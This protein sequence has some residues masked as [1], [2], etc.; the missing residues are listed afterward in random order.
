MIE[1]VI[2]TS[3]RSLFYGS[4]LSSLQKW[5]DDN[6]PIRQEYENVTSMATANILFVN[7]VLCGIIVDLGQDLKQDGLLKREVKML[8]NQLTAERTKYEKT[9]N[10]STG[11][12]CMEQFADQ[13]EHFYEGVR[14]DL[15]VAYYTVKS[16]CDRLRVPAS[17]SMTRLHQARLVS[18]ASIDICKVWEE[19]MHKYLPEKFSAYSIR[20]LRLESVYGCIKK[21]HA[22]LFTPYLKKFGEEE[23]ADGSMKADEILLKRLVDTKLIYSAATYKGEDCA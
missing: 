14:H 2:N 10:R 9:I 7:D 22:L 21:L 6:H 4:M 15:Q 18:R 12:E 19:R 20:N 5:K 8:Y 11:A 17:S 1:G 23:V 3:R 16:E 13:Q